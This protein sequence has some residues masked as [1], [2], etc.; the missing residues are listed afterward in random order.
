M[1]YS[2]SR[3]A[4]GQRKL[5]PSK[6]VGLDNILMDCALQD[7]LDK[8]TAQTAGKLDILHCSLQVI[9]DRKSVV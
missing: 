1:H 6:K 7:D 2:I 5:L 4:I 8:D 3:C 9:K